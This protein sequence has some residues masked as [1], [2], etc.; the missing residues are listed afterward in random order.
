MA[1]ITLTIPDEQ[2]PRIRAA[3]CTH[4]GLTESNANA[5]KVVIQMVRQVVQ[6]IEHNAA[7]TAQAA[8]VIPD[9][10]IT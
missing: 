3:L 7:V 8:I 4:G 6:Q 9:D 5:K 10:I 1:S 2:L